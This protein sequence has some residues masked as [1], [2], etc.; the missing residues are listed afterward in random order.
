MKEFIE[1]IDRLAKAT[2]RGLPYFMD[3]HVETIG[4]CYNK[5]RHGDP[6]PAKT[7]GVETRQYRF[8]HDAICKIHPGRRFYK[9][10]KYFEHIGDRYTARVSVKHE[11]IATER[12]KAPTVHSFHSIII[13]W[14]Q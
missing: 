2:M 13:Q 6:S 7:E 14:K 11:K 5:L 8:A 12:G 4:K 9:R 1:H 10:R 3:C